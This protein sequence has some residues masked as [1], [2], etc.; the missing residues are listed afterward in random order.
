MELME[1]QP[2][3]LLEEVALAA[4]LLPWQGCFSGPVARQLMGLALQKK[5]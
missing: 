5:L 3:Q 4:P 2:Q 1:P